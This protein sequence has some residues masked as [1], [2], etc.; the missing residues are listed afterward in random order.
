M[1]DYL[2][3]EHQVG[4][5]RMQPAGAGMMATITTNQTESG[6]ALNRRVE[7]VEMEN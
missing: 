3:D 7:L 1:V 2:V 4:A 5:E 6:R